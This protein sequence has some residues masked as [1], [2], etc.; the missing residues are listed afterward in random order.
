MHKAM[1]CGCVGGHGERR[2]CRVTLSN[3]MAEICC[4]CKISCCCN[5]AS[6][7][8]K[9][10]G[11]ARFDATPNA[12]EFT[13]QFFKLLDQIIRSVDALSRH[14]DKQISN[15]TGFCCNGAGCTAHFILQATP[16]RLKWCQALIGSATRGVFQLLDHQGNG[17]SLLAH[18]HHMLHAQHQPS[19]E[20]GQMLICQRLCFLGRI[21]QCCC[22]CLGGIWYRGVH[23]RSQIPAVCCQTLDL[24]GIHRGHS[25]N[26]LHRAAAV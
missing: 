8:A 7:P 9:A 18:L 15:A 23:D 21:F 19:V 26:G 4:A 10:G 5:T 17:I 16:S 2:I 11:R 20:A 14:G 6:Q 1:V 22:Q 24:A 25:R 3:D 13:R 12:G